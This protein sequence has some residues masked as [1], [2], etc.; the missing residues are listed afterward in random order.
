MAD[1]AHGNGCVERERQST[2]DTTSTGL[3]MADTLNT[4]NATLLNTARMGR[5]TSTG[6]GVAR[7]QNTGGERG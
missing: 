1:A 6:P 5:E 4:V 7:R 2:V 3:E